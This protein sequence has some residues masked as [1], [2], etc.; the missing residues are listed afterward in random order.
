M[1]WLKVILLKF[2]WDWTSE[3]YTACMALAVG[4]IY[5]TG[6]DSSGAEWMIQVLCPVTLYCVCVKEQQQQHC[7]AMYNVYFVKRFVMH[8][9]KLHTDLTELNSHAYCMPVTLS[10]GLFRI[11]Y[12][13]SWATWKFERSRLWELE[14]SAYLFILGKPFLCVIWTLEPELLPVSSTHR[15]SSFTSN[16][17]LSF[18]LQR[19]TAVAGSR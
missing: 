2:S 7:C 14:C 13:K 4:F 17:W 15:L 18:Q 1:S 8:S 19:I 3:C 12:C 6:F 10:I 16:P 5:A 11:V 9:Q